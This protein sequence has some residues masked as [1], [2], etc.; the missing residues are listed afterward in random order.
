[1]PYLYFDWPLRF[2]MNYYIFGISIFIQFNIHPTLCE[3]KYQTNQNGKSRTF[4]V[5]QHL[6]NADCFIMKA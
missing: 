2:R 6:L 5:I 4:R 3:I 1:M